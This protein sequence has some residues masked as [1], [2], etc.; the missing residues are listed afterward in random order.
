M[1]ESLPTL[2][3]TLVTELDLPEALNDGSV[4]ESLPVAPVS[5]PSHDEPVVT[6][7][8]RW[9]YYCVYHASFFLLGN[10]MDVLSSVYHFGNN[11]RSSSPA[12]FPEHGFLMLILDACVQYAGTWTRW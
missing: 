1:S 2:E 10:L 11:V 5:A 4:S 8:E 7:R 12:R 6:R 3:A 9:S